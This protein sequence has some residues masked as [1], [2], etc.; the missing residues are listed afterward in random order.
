MALSDKPHLYYEIQQGNVNTAVVSQAFRKVLEELI[1]SVADN[2]ETVFTRYMG[3]AN[4][5][6]S[7]EENEISGESP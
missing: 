6:L 4:Q 5:R 7:A 3:A 2:D 1:S